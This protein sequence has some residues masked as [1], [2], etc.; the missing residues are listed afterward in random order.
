MELNGL[1]NCRQLHLSADSSTGGIPMIPAA[2][3]PGVPTSPE[4]GLVTPAHK[5]V[6]Q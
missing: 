1:H 4:A 2:C 5:V 6:R 3:V